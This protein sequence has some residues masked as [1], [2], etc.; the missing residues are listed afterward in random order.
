MMLCFQRALA[1]IRSFVGGLLVLLD[2]PSNI[3]LFTHSLGGASDAH[4]RPDGISG[5]TRGEN[6]QISR[7][8]VIQSEGEL[9][10]S[11]FQRAFDDLSQSGSRLVKRC[12]IHLAILTVG[13]SK[14]N[15]PLVLAHAGGK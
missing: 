11:N 9:G 6:D 7:S 4:Q 13:T 5:V 12:A 3:D 2:G 8:L 15:G 1:G 14:R 10:F